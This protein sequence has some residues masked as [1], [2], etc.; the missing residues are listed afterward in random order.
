MDDKSS[1]NTMDMALGP[2]VSLSPRSPPSS[3]SGDGD[4]S[5]S[6]GSGSSGGDE[7]PE[8]KKKQ[9]AARAAFR[10]QNGLDAGKIESSRKKKLD[11]ASTMTGG[12]IGLR[13]KRRRLRRH[14]NEN[15]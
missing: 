12:G 14:A 9:L 13:R 5:S 15:M 2:G 8:W 3:S 7:I 6:V 11:A 1:Q 10:A 4:S